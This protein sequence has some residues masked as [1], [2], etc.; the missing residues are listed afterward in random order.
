MAATATDQEGKQR[1]RWL[2]IVL[3]A[4]GLITLARLVYV[5]L[6]QHGHFVALAASEHQR[7]YEVPADRGQ[8]YLLDGDTKVPLALNETLKL[9]YADPSI[10]KDKQDTANKLA[11]VTGEP[12]SKYLDALNKGKEYAVLKGR[13][14]EAEAKKIKALN[15]RG[16]GMVNEDY[17][18]Y[19]E[20]QLG[21]QVLGFVNNDGDGQYGVEGYLNKKL[22]GEPGV[23]NAKT[24]TNG[25]PIATAENLSK[26]PVAG[27]S[28]VLTIDRNIQ[29]Q[30]EQFLK[31]GVTAVHAESGSVIVMDP[32]TGAIKAMANYPSFDPNS[33][34]SVKDYT[35]F[36]NGVVSD[37]F[38]PGSGFKV[39]T[40]AAGLDSGKVTPT[41]TY[42]D[43]GC[44][45]LD[46]YKIC[47]AENH[48]EGPNT[49]M[50]TVLK[51]SLNTGV[52]FVLR[53]LGTDPNSITPAAKQAFN[54]YV[55]QHFG[56]GH[57][58]GI[59]QAGES[60]GDINPP[61][62]NNVNYANMTFGQGLS[63][64]MLQMATA[65]SAI[66]NGG[67]LYKPYLIDRTVSPDGTEHD[68][69]PQVTNSHVISQQAAKDLTA[70]MVT[71]VEQGSGHRAKTAGYAIA[72]KT[73]TAQIP[74]PNGKGYLEDQNIGTFVGFAPAQDPKF[75]VM[76]RVNKPKFQGFAETT[77]V[78]IFGNLT[79]W[80]LQYEAVPPSS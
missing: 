52:M 68:T 64:T 53:Q 28:V 1:L 54:N 34:T 41:T 45:Q 42:T 29:A 69:K 40:M 62:S 11:A 43:N 35:T 76:V 73:G 67:K 6:V 2:Y 66:A 27:E 17:R 44:E 56:F 33:Y 8:I 31:E 55:T 32:N 30:A 25:I 59:E 60:A 3:I 78:P 72:G 19:P 21:S 16:V 7:K 80:L 48:K 12:A 49:T 77:T 61:T 57:T 24:D 65:V 13:V 47:N 22:K 58:T 71:T 14:N 9:V 18:T 5:Q 75:V 37:A 4:L 70:M 10:V 36:S 15:L 38:E 63:V 51:D 39:I 50:T 23:L 79:R 26:A 20:G 46:N 74:N